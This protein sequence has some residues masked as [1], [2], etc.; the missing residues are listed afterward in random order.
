MP[1]Y[2]SNN[3]KRSGLE[4]QAN[5]MHELTRRTYDS[6]RKLSELN[7]QLAQQIMHESVEA[8]RAMLNCS[9]PCQMAA[10]G[11]ASVAPGAQHLQ[12]YHRQLIGLLTGGQFELMSRAEPGIQQASRSGYGAG[13]EASR[14]MT[15]PADAAAKAARPE[16]RSTPSYGGNGHAAPH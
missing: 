1:S 11:A 15:R 2:S 4:A 8:S 10:A 6:V 9:D 3:T 12:Y 13:Q 7:I 16:E 14:S 5:F